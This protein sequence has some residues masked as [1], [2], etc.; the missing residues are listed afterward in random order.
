MAD[1]MNIITM[2]LPGVAVT[3]YGE[4]IAMTNNMNSDAAVALT[5]MTPRGQFGWNGNRESSNFPTLR[6]SSNLRFSSCT[7]AA[8]AL[9]QSIP[10]AT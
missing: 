8:G 3:Y 10:A 1:I 7:I 5:E 4:E 9:L 6:H 2:T